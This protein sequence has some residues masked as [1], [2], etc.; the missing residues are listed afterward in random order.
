VTT[1]FVPHGSAARP[2]RILLVEDDEAHARLAT[3]WLEEAGQGRFGIVRVERLSEAVAELAAGAVDAVL[4]DLSL[5]DSDGLET[6]RVA[7]GQAPTTPVVVMTGNGDERLALQAVQEGAQD[8]LV[9]G[10][11]DGRLVVRA[12]RHAI[13]RARAEAAERR[14]LQ[15]QRLESLSLLAGGIAHQLNNLLMVI[16][17][18][19]SLAATALEV[20]DPLREYLVEIESASQQAARLAR[21]MLAYSGRGGFTVRPVDLNEIV[22]SACAAFSERVPAHVAVRLELAP[23]PLRV[24]ADE[25]QIAQLVLN[26]MINASEALGPEGGEVLMTTRAVDAGPSDFERAYTTPD[27]PAGAY[28][29]LV[30]ADTGEGISPDVA[31]HIFEPFFS[32]RLTGRG[33]GLPAAL[34]IVRGHGGAIGIDSTPGQGTRVRVLLPAHVEDRAGK[35]DTGT[36]S[37]RS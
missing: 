14:L 9:K 11:I 31:E 21:Q 7:R 36:A 28:M 1:P 15:A 19:A 10:D 18:N 26:L 12:L 35:G 23:A 13:E 16:L 30:I 22:H 17:G 24:A 34:G 2:L 33:L 20:D 25:T 37:S 29:E 8:Y 4:L 3:L 32:T 6:F 5:P 27:L